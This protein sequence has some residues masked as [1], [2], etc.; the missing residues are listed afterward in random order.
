MARATENVAVTSLLLRHNTMIKAAC[1]RERD[2]A[3]TFQSD[4]R[5][6]DKEA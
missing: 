4:K 6:F 1:R 3:L 2:M 5:P